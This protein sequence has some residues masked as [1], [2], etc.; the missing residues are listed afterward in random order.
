[1]VPWSLGSGV[2]DVENGQVR[3]LFVPPGIY[4]GQKGDHA[5]Y[6]TAME[7]EVCGS[8]DSHKG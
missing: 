5:I 6:L 1:M 2:K 8:G 4:V 7:P 3:D